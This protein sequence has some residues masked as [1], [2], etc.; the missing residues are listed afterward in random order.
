MTKDC[1]Y[2]VDGSGYIFRAYHALPPLYR[3]SDGLPT[4]AVLGFINMLNKL[5]EE[6]FNNRKASHLVI[7]FDKGSKTFRNEIFKDYK[8]NRGETP[9]DLI[10]QFQLIKD[11]TKIFNIAMVEEEGYEA[12]DIIASYAKVSAKNDFE[13]KIV[14][15]DKDLMQLVEPGISMLDPMK[16][17]IINEKEVF[18]KFGVAPNKVIDVQSLAGDSSDNV[19]GV[20]GIGIKTAAELINKFGDLDS[21]LE[22]AEQIKQPK[23]R[24]K[25][26]E[27]AGDAILSRKLVTLKN[28]IKIKIPLDKLKY[29]PPEY[30]KVIEFLKEMEFTSLVNRLTRKSDNNEL[31]NYVSDTNYE[32]NYQVCLSAADI[33]KYQDLA[34]RNGICSIIIF[35]D[36]LTFGK[37]NISGLSMC[38]E[39]GKCVFFPINGRSEK[40]GIGLKKLI[41]SFAKLF[42][43]NA[44]VKIFYNVK[45]VLKIVKEYGI[46][47][48]SYDDVMLMSYNSGTGKYNHN[49]SEIMKAHLESAY[50][51]P[52][53]ILGSG[54]LKKNINEIDIEVLR[55]FSCSISD[56]IMQLQNLLKIELVMSR[57]YN[58]HHNIDKPMINI[59]DKVE[60]KGVLINT[61]IL[62]QI[63]I[64]FHSRL[65][66]L[67]EKI[68]KES[69][70]EFNIGSPKQL[71]EVLFDEMG[72]EGGKKSKGGSWSTGAE[73]LDLLSQQG[74]KIAE[75]VLDWRQLAK[76][77]N[78]YSEKLPLLVDSNTKR[79]H[80]TYLIA[81]TSTGRLSSN[82]PN[83]QNIPIRTE[84]G[85]KIREAFIAPENFILL[86]ADY[87]QIEL[88]LL[89]HMADVPQLS[90]AFEDNLDIHSAT[91]SQVFGVSNEEVSSDL[92][93]R[94]KAINF[95][96][97]YGISPFGLA[98]QL[99][100]SNNEAK[101]YISNYFKQF[102]G[103]Q[104]YMSSQI[105]FCKI[106]GYVT[107]SFG[108]RIYISNINNKNNTIKSFAERQAI[109]APLQGGAADIIKMAMIEISKEIETSNNKLALLLQVHDELVFE[110][111]ESEVE[112]FAKKIKKTMEEVINLRVPLVVDIGTG[113][114][115]SE[116]H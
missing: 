53:E 65:E 62:K 49:L 102:P 59:L 4:G 19:P 71:G 80:T 60:N 89:A 108:R 22:S 78:T 36:Q 104:D 44:T 50:Y 72:I 23:R 73:I 56:S 111:L 6:H 8:A 114:N 97:I 30:T 43:C 91:A 9:E 58:I 24:E 32:K 85:R 92:R 107:T 13:V 47:L 75:L 84:D 1:I 15:S 90:Q 57:S 74:I 106:N 14:S 40:E 48:S 18:E 3:K 100:I 93:R 41:T 67:E 105:D 16:N 20:P 113:K 79:I 88:R 45:Q 70:R 86:S 83:L 82:D 101:E 17:K 7:I 28:D 77:I 87:S 63:S 103:I 115:W 51:K 27:F 76:L 116:A 2:L 109:N 112:V 94:A 99:N 66:L 61:E 33:E 110:A 39:L 98:K 68:F 25:L 46:L 11:A 38:Y 35:D 69:G 5:I 55:N 29:T 31:N 10:P 95:G 37:E 54:K 64:Q 52:E 42:E 21:L 34:I 12:D 96:I 81:S 26:I